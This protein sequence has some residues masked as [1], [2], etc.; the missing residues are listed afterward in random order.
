M[1]LAVA[2]EFDHRFASSFGGPKTKPKKERR[3][4]VA[5]RKQK[6]PTKPLHG[7]RL[8]KLLVRAAFAKEVFAALDESDDEGEDDEFELS[9]DADFSGVWSAAPDPEYAAY[10]EYHDYRHRQYDADSG[11][12]AVCCEPFEFDGQFD[13][14]FRCGDDDGSD[15]EVLFE[16]GLRDPPHPADDDVPLAADLDHALTLAGD[17]RAPK[18]K[19]RQRQRQRRHQRR[20]GVCDGQAKRAAIGAERRCCVDCI[21]RTISM[22]FER[23]PMADKVPCPRCGLPFSLPIVREFLESGQ[24]EAEKARSLLEHICTTEAR[25]AALA[26]ERS[27]GAPASFEH[28]IGPGCNE[29]FLFSWSSPCSLVTCGACKF[30]ACVVCKTAYHVGVTCAQALRTRPALQWRHENTK[31]CPFC[32]T[33]IEKN[34]GCDHHHCTLCGTDFSWERAPSGVFGLAQMT[35]ALKSVPALPKRKTRVSEPTKTAAVAVAPTAAATAA[36]AAVPTETQPIWMR[37]IRI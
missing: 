5:L 10:A 31:A 12:C 14:Q 20:A 11:I 27:R 8:E 30:S 26:H 18:P 24:V 2:S 23:K 9:A 33:S 17:L 25:L 16:D 6:F 35:R 1:S 22:T 3:E 28:C 7:T 34:G 21:V 19:R 15:D 32:F 37:S 29:V 13:G 36:A 4:T